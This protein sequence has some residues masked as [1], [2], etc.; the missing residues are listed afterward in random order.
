M[1][2]YVVTAIQHYASVQPGFFL[3]EASNQK[4]AKLLPT[5]NALAN[6]VYSEK[7]GVSISLEWSSQ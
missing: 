2:W 3:G 1:H 4:P 6:N 5:A 7:Y